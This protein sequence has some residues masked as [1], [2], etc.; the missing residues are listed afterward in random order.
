MAAKVR[1]VRI[2]RGDVDFHVDFFK[3][4]RRRTISN[5]VRAQSKNYREP[6]FKVEVSSTLQLKS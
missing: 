5:P 3:A 2:T 6:P 4:R 1:P